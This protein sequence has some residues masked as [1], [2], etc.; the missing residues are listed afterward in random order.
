M[1]DTIVLEATKRDLIGKQVKQL[2]AEGIIPGVLYGP[3]FDALH[4]Q[5]KW[6]E[7]RPT[8]LEVGGSQ[9]IQL[10][11]DGEKY[12]AL[13]RDV[14]RAPVR[15]DVLHI[16]FYR[17]RMDV[18]IRTEVPINVVGEAEAIILDGGIVSQEMTSIEVECLPLSLPSHI[19]VD[20]SGLKE[21]G[22]SL[23]V[24]DLPQLEGVTYLT[25]PDHIVVTTSYPRGAIEAET[26]DEGF[27]ADSAEPE[28]VRR[29]DEDM[30][31]E[32]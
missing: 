17:V 15:G 10:D 24:A 11:V 29:R 7:L 16:D 14:Q 6:T 13:V 28:L 19:D 2:R 18:A 8:L 3:E 20:I 22:D 31:D 1:A 25:D 32:V 4:V 23:N 12:N 27:I 30:D 9:I 5:V 21:V 26:A